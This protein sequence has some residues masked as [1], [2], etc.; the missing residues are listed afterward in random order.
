MGISIYCYEPQAWLVC[1][2]GLWVLL[3]GGGVSKVQIFVAYLPRA[4]EKRIPKRLSHPLHYQRRVPNFEHG[5]EELY[6]ELY[7]QDPGT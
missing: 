6:E 5:S 2:V 3:W 4:A 7:L 1:F